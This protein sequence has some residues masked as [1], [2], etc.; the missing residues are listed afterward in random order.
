MA[1]SAKKIVKM[2]RISCLLLISLF[3]I[4]GCTEKSTVKMPYY[5]TAD[6]TPVFVDDTAEIAGKI[7]HR[8]AD[9]SF[10]DQHAATITQRN[11]EGKVHVANFFFTSCGSIC[12]KM[13]ANLK[14]ISDAFRNN[15]QVQ[16]LS[17]SATPWLDSVPRL[18]KYADRNGYTS[19]N[20]HLLTG[21]RSEIYQ[22]ARTSYFAEESI[23][24]TKDST[25]F[26]HTEHFLLIDRHKR[27]RG[28]YNGTLELEAQQLITDI[29]TLLTE[30]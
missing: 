12:P 19:P 11:I 29:G 2:F 8:L 1:F 4:T 30:D 23:G 15:G 28:I 6:F 17:Y 27:I 13:M 3:F 14:K 21:K 22:L 24:F 26:L 7:T 18:K 5:N 25:Q 10:T 16:L 20:W 9:F